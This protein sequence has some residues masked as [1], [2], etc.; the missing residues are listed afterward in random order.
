MSNP[1][2]FAHWTRI[3]AAIHICSEMHS[4][5]VVVFFVVCFIRV[6]AFECRV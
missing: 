6:P 4:P 1:A 5:L 2:H 3:R